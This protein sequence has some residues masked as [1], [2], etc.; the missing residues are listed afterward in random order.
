MVKWSTSFEQES[1]E[2]SRPKRT[3]LI[4]Q[5]AM[6]KKKAS[7]LFWLWHLLVVVVASNEPPRESYH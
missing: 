4:E 5:R 2:K 1:T 6:P 7:F 3:Y